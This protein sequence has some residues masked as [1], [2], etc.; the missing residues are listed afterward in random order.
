MTE[1]NKDQ[2]ETHKRKLTLSA[3]LNPKLNSN[4]YLFGKEWT[5][6]FFPE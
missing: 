4:I 6:S 1:R 5:E 3:C 2:A